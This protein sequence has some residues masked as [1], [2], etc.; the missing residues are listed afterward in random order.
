MPKLVLIFFVVPLTA[1][2]RDIH[3]ALFIWKSCR[4]WTRQFL[5]NMDLK[6]QQLRSR[7]YSLDLPRSP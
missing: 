2:S 6:T 4:S 5:G 7:H 1:G 3:K